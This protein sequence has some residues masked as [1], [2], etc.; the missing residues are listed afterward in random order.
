MINAPFIHTEKTY[1]TIM[2]DILIALSPV[3]VWSVF[4]FGARVL[5]I[6]FLSVSASVVFDFLARYLFGRHEF[7]H[8]LRQATDLSAVVTGLL[9][10]F[11]LPVT[12]PLYL[13]V[14]ASFFAIVLVKQA[15]GGIG[16]NLLNPAV[17]SI[18][19]IHI[20][21]PSFVDKFTMPY[22]Y[23]NAF[24]S[25]LGTSLIDS[26]RVFSPLQMLGREHVYE[27]GFTDLF[28]GTT[29]GN[30]GEIA[31]LFILLG[32]VYLA[33]R[34]IIDLRGSV[35]YIATVFFLAFLFPRGNGETIYFALTEMMS[36]GV[37][38]LAVFACNDFTTT[39]KQNTGKII[40]GF[41]CG[42]LT[43]V[44]R[45]FFSHFEGAYI[46]VLLMNLLT[47]FINKFTRTVPFGMLK[48]KKTV[49][50]KEP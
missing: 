12:V 31:I 42:V 39:P 33:F 30:I 32:G 9:I 15:F 26:V 50:I 43:I 45:Y 40:F 38:L 28:Y 25:E 34:K 23:F 1:R 24:T 10:T 16:R 21:L 48:Q 41:G 20:V 5:T 46:A 4:A 3:L 14:F 2:T 6:A 7:K 22:A 17:F 8:A 19:V 13:P 11:M 47:P 36:G 49:S 37:I 44:I 27:E 29:P 18:A 35:A